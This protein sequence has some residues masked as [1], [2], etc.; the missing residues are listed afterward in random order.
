[1]A[2]DSMDMNAIPRFLIR[3]Q[4]VKDLSFE[5][6]LAPHTL[7]NPEEKPDIS[8]DIS[9]KAQRLNEEHF[10]LVL[11]IA[12]TAKSKEKM[13][14]LVELDYGAIVQLVNIPEDRI[15]QLLFIDCAAILFP[16]ARRVLSDV[17]RDGGFMPMMLEPIDFT[18]L[19]ARN[20]MAETQEARQD[21]KA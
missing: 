20:K 14:F 2:E 6:P 11:R 19:Y 15:E 10:E 4:Y 12:S 8:V 16:F 13:L 5:N 3:G 17:T 9:L 1:M 18:A 7:V 21:A